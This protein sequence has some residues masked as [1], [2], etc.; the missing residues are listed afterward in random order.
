MEN[1]E[2]WTPAHLAGVLN[3]F[4]S[5]NLLIENGADITKKHQGNLSTYEEMVRCDNAELLEC[6]YPLIKAD[7]ANRS[8]KGSGAF[9]IIHLAASSNGPKCLD[10]L[11]KQDGESPN[12][13]CNEEERASP[14][15]FAILSKQLEN[16]KILL[17]NNASPNS[18]D[19]MG[20][21]PMHV[22]VSSR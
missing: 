14:L 12:T 2:G 22:A 19:A 10:F 20:N 7:Q 5:L 11:L 1:M 21:T 6:I 8:Y 3:N 4:D 9:G 13:I 17:R 18:R 16:V 15:H